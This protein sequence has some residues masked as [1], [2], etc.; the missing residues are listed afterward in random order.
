MCAS[1]CARVS[2]LMRCVNWCHQSLRMLQ[3]VLCVSCD[4]LKI[5]HFVTPM[6]YA[7]IHSRHDARRRT[8]SYF[9]K[10]WLQSHCDANASGMACKMNL[11]YIHGNRLT[12][13]PF[14]SGEF[15]NKI[16]FID[17]NFN[18]IIASTYN[19]QSH[20]NAHA[21][22]EIAK[23]I[24]RQWQQPQYILLTTRRRTIFMW[25]FDYRKKRRKKFYEF[26]FRNQSH[27]TTRV[28][29]PIR[30]IIYVT[31][32]CQDKMWWFFL[33]ILFLISDFIRVDSGSAGARRIV[34]TL[35]VWP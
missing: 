7:I 19:T 34:F 13:D 26:S 22:H 25:I 33:C 11:V 21:T 28:M 29:E 12:N 23:Q 24:R 30:I 9:D 20:T 35:F 17:K 31:R 15:G 3:N 1:S 4:K 14:H 6:R 10:L 18:R 32:A 16:N 8:F 5:C 27:Q 2:L